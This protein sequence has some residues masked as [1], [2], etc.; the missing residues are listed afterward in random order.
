MVV[1]MRMQSASRPD[2]GPQPR[3]RPRA[4][5]AAGFPEDGSDSTHPSSPHPFFFFFNYYFLFA[6]TYFTGFG[7]LLS[8]GACPKVWGAGAEPGCGMR[9]RDAAAAGQGMRFGCS[10]RKSPPAVLR[11]AT[12]KTDP[13][14]ISY[15]KRYECRRRRNPSVFFVSKNVMCHLLI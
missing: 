15:R 6:C 5:M 7:C 3:H 8:H 12:Y 2:H 13:L 14:H 11:H 1:E 9:E 4:P 10:L